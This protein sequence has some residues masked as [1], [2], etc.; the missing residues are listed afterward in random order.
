MEITVYN[1]II[2][3]MDIRTNVTVVMQQQ[4]KAFHTVERT[5]S[6]RSPTMYKEIAKSN[7]GAMINN[8]K[9]RFSI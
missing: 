2:S 1:E 5:L 3:A 7:M 6:L 8:R 4:L 9:A